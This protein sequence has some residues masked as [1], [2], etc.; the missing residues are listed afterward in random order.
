MI[1]N[2]PLSGARLIGTRDKVTRIAEDWKSKIPDIE[3]WDAADLSRMLDNN[4]NVRTT[5]NDLIL[6]GDILAALRNQIQSQTNRVDSAFRGYLL[7][8]I[9]NESKARAEEA[10]DDNPLPLS[11]VFVDQTLTLDKKSIPESYREMI[12]G[13][14]SDYSCKPGM[15]LLIPE[16]LESVP[17]HFHYFGEPKK[18]LCF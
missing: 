2:V 7:H 11:K 3:V 18:K 14:T 9:D 1:T 17:P 12:H 13:W 10:G 15:S 4:P 6:P 5:Y 8:V 16:D